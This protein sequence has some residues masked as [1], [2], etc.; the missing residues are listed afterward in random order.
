MDIFSTMEK[1]TTQEKC[2]EFLEELRWRGNVCC[3][4]CGSL[5]VGRK[6]KNNIAHGWNCYDCGSAFTVTAGTMF[7]KTK[8]PLR[9]WFVAISIMLNS[10]KGIS[11]IALARHLDMNQKSA[12]YM[13]MRIRNHMKDDILLKGI[14]E[15]DETYVGGKPRHRAKRKDK[16]QGTKKVPVVGAVQRGGKIIAKFIGELG[17]GN[18]RNFL[19]KH[20]EKGTTL[21]TDGFS[22]YK[23]VEDYM[24]RKIINHK[25]KYVDGDIYT[26]TIEGF[27]SEVKRAF[28]GVHHWYSTKWLPLYIQESCFKRNHK[29]DEDV[30]ADFLKMSVSPSNI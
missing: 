28:Y 17:G 1:F 8:I 25:E 26:N 22:G 29:D 24:D 14:V 15:A 18:L 16:K 3:I 4:H 6:N 11:S 23:S 7:H 19:L 21:M 10:K 13:Q 20:I 5:W 2:L 27:W 30:F 9:K 12:W